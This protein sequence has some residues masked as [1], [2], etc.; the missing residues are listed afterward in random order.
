MDSV[1]LLG[2]RHAALPARD[3]ARGLR[4]YVE[5]LGFSDYHSGDADWAMLHLAGTTLSL[6][7]VREDLAAPKAR[8]KHPAHLGL[9]ASTPQEVD[10]M[11]ERLARVPEAKAG[12]T[13]RHRDG[14]YGFYFQDTEGNAL[15]CI[16]IPQRSH[17][18]PAPEATGAILLAHGSAD[19]AWREPFEALAAAV[20]LHLPGVPAELAYMEAASPS[21]SEAATRLLAGRA[22]RTV[23]VLPIFMSAGAH[24]TKD[25]PRQLEGVERAHPGVRFVL[26]PALGSAPEIREALVGLVA[27]R[28]HGAGGET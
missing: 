14:S 28:V 18:R 10:R 11:R 25:I 4:F 1:E 2:I 5:H 24:L 8:G 6:I 15:E 27:D 12:P 13:V 3:L 17:T 7:Q 23:H 16:F 21:L 22:L 26:A 20:S 9:V 19:P